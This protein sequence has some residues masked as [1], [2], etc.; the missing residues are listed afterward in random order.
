M[1]R[2]KIVGALR[3]YMEQEVLEGDAED[4]DGSTQLLELGLIDSFSIMGL[5]SFIETEYGVE[6]PLESITPE[7]IQDLDAIASLVLATQAASSPKS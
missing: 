6:I 4:L 3:A 1:D 5:M 2:E 7:T